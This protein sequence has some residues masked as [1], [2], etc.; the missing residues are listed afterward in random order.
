V[1]LEFRDGRLLYNGGDGTRWNQVAM[2]RGVDV[3]MPATSNTVEC[4]NGHL[5][6][7]APRHGTFL[8]SLHRVAEMFTVWIEHFG[9]C[10]QHNM[11]YEVHGAGDRHRRVHPDQMAKEMILFGTE[12]ARCLCG[13]AILAGQMYRYNIPCGHR[14]AHW[15]RDPRDPWERDG[16]V[17]PPDHRAGSFRTIGLAA[18][19]RW[20]SCE[21][22]VE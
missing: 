19:N 13:E 9:S 15:R 11:V 3:G 21:F 22:T 12:A 2:V 20:L 16:G 1:G 5:N 4:L 17:M 10:W 18:V 8:G 6:G 7:V 14:V